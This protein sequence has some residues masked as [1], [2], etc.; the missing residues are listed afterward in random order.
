MFNMSSKLT[1]PIFKAG[2][3]LPKKNVDDDVGELYD[4]L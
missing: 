3:S 2:G 1:A 4:S